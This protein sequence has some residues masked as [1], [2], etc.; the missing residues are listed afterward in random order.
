MCLRCAV[1]SFFGACAE[2]ADSGL[3]GRWASTGRDRSDAQ[4]ERGQ[5]EDVFHFVSWVKVDMTL[6]L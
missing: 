1:A 3:V 2:S 6:V 4:D 5:D